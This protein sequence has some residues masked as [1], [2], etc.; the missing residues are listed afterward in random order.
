M[1]DVGAGNGVVP[2]L[3]QTGTQQLDAV[4]GLLQLPAAVHRLHGQKSAPY[5]DIGQ[6]Q[7]TM[8]SELD[9]ANEQIK[10][11]AEERQAAKDQV[12]RLE[13]ELGRNKHR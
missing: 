8:Q 6:A 3:L 11:L 2:A 7:L 10:K 9:K 4:G 12:I 5:L 13:T 1:N